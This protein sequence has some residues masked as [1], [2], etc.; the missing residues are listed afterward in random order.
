MSQV[1]S[2][3]SEVFP[4]SSGPTRSVTGTA[5]HCPPRPRQGGTSFFGNVRLG[6]AGA[7]MTIQNGENRATCP[8]VT[9]PASAHTAIESPSSVYLSLAYSERVHK[10][11]NS[12]VTGG[13]A[14]RCG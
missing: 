3:S 8:K 12:H 10:Q 9:L 1:V 7:R 2:W 14:A 6:W 5:R 4:S 13:R 11:G